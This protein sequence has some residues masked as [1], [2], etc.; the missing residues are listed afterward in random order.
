VH[1][2]ETLLNSPYEFKG[3]KDLLPFTSFIKDCK[4]ALLATVKP[5]DRTT[6]DL[7]VSKLGQDPLLQGL[8]VLGIDT[9]GTCSMSSWVQL[10]GHLYEAWLR[11]HLRSQ[12]FSV[13]YTFYNDSQIEYLGVKGHYDFVLEVDGIDY[14]CEIK[15]V[16]DAY[17]GSILE[18]EKV[19]NPRTG[20]LVRTG[21]YLSKFNESALNNDSRGYIT[22]LSVYSEALGMPG[23]LFLWNKTK[24]RLNVVPLNQELKDLALLRVDAIVP[25]LQS[26]QTIEE[27]FFKFPVP[28]PIEKIRSGKGTG[29]FFLPMVTRFCNEEL[30]NC[31]Y[32][33]DDESG[34]VLDVRDRQMSVSLIK[35]FLEGK[36]GD[37]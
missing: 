37:C 2:L 17:I 31:I 19:E 24:N 23:L 22:Q 4:E 20:R 36:N 6:K 9:Q 14:V 3:F 25:E 26:L 35:Y 33:I 12:G 29:E 18:P 28:A 1:S 13:K 27:V 32:E 10:A 16:S 5:H 11:F 34:A 7:R 8:S 15:H 30:L 21:R